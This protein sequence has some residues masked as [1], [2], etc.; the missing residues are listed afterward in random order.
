MIEITLTVLYADDPGEDVGAAARGLAEVLRDEQLGVVHAEG[1][2]TAVGLAALRRF[3]GQ[4]LCVDLGD[5]LIHGGELTGTARVQGD[6]FTV[7]G[8]P[9]DPARIWHLDRDDGLT[10]PDNAR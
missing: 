10:A 2:P 8:V 9:V 7:D 5:S 1:R 3:D 4:R 6:Q